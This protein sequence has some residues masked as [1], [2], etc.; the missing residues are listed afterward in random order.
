MHAKPA[1]VLVCSLLFALAG[2]VSQSTNLNSVH[3][4]MARSDLVAHLGKPDSTRTQGD[5][6]YL[7]YY[8]STDVKSRE[9][10]YMIRLI[11]AKVE[12]FGRFIQLV[13]THDGSTAGATPLGI[14]V[15]MPYAMNLDVVTQLQRLQALQDQGVL[16]AEEVARAKERLL[17]KTD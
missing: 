7:T 4:G 8:L 2:C 10:P 17:A 3:L 5:A 6:E 11:D 16:T 15:I 1:A 12:S 9:Q 14:G 13:D